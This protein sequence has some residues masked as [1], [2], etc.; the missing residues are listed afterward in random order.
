MTPIRRGNGPS[1]FPAIDHKKVF[2]WVTPQKIARSTQN[3]ETHPSYLAALI[4]S[5]WIIRINF[6]GPNQNI[7]AHFVQKVSSYLPL[8]QNFARFIPNSIFHILPI[9]VTIFGPNIVIFRDQT[10]N[11]YDSIRSFSVIRSLKVFFGPINIF[12]F[13][14]D[15]LHRFYGPIKLFLGLIRSEPPFLR[16]IQ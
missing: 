7:I 8:N 5:L 1:W 11:F 3:E 12:F 9:F 4:R 14:S 15:L 2:L 13:W 6:L 10:P 16:L